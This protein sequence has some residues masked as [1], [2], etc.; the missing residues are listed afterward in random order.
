MPHL[1]AAIETR[2][3]AHSRRKLARYLP[4][5]TGGGYALAVFTGFVELA[6]GLAAAGVKRPA[7]LASAQLG[8]QCATPVVA[9]ALTTRAASVAA[10]R[11]TGLAAHV[12]GLALT[13]RAGL[14]SAAL[15]PIGVLIAITAAAQAVATVRPARNGTPG[16]PAI[17][18][19]SALAYP[20]TTADVVA[21]DHRAWTAQ[22]ALEAM[23]VTAATQEKVPAGDGTARS[24]GKL[25]RA[26]ASQIKDVEFHQG[27]GKARGTQ[28]GVPIIKSRL[29]SCRIR[30]I[31]PQA[32][33]AIGAVVC[34]TWLVPARAGTAVL[35]HLA[36]RGATGGNIWGEMRL[37]FGSGR[38]A[39]SNAAAAENPNRLKKQTSQNR[40]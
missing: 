13:G 9:V 31:R 11:L 18:V 34:F 8:R 37:P 28:V 32:V 33:I 29:F 39:S 23:V 10:D 12:S 20:L 6:A 2:R 35:A 4:L 7:T 26:H 27:P 21:D 38:G 1:R 5:G 30:A 3:A 25:A 22:V 24:E 14:L 17:A 16:T 15:L 36:G 40:S 19:I